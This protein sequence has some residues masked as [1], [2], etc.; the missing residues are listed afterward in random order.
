MLLVNAD[1]LGWDKNITDR[2]LD[3]YNK[4][5]IHSASILTFMADSQRAVDLSRDIQLPIGLHLNLDEE[6]TGQN[7]PV[8]LKRHHRAVS[9]YLLAHKW[10][11]VL[12]NPFLRESFDYVFKTQ[13]DEYCRLYSAEPHW[14][15][16]HHH[17]HL[18][19]NILLSGKLPAGIRIRRNFTFNPGEKNPINRLYRNLVDRWLTTR[20]RCTDSFFSLKPINLEKLRTLVLRSQ[21]S[22]VEIMVH[23]GVDNEYLFLLSPEWDILISKANQV[24]LENLVNS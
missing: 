7:T 12:Y 8:K 20:F 3:S 16:G 4:K 23:P 24:K 10:N 2:I 11:Q 14:L 19:M 21:S 22:D 6:F 13:W 5:R 15:D 18:C 1:D 9:S 17:F